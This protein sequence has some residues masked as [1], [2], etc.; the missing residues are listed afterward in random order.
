[1]WMYPFAVFDYGTVLLRGVRILRKIAWTAANPEN[2]ANNPGREHG[3]TEISHRSV[4]D[5]PRGGVSSDN[6]W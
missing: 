4:H 5:N 2:G 1:M 6:R 3:S